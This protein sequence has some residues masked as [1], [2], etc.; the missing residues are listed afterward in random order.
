MVY[1]IRSISSKTG[2][3]DYAL[4]GETVELS[5]H[6]MLKDEFEDIKSVVWSK[7]GQNVSIKHAKIQLITC[8]DWPSQTIN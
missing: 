1:Q 5:C 3:T 8:F 7:D 6:Y 4:S 2:R